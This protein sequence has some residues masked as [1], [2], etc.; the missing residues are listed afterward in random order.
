MRSLNIVEASIDNRRSYLYI[1]I[2]SKQIYIYRKE[3]LLIIYAYELEVLASLRVLRRDLAV[4]CKD[5]RDYGLY[6]KRTDGG[7]LEL[8]S[9][10]T[11]RVRFTTML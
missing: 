9:I 2:V 6:F 5:Q 7:S 10:I 3:I 8:V 11:V 1:V 4:R